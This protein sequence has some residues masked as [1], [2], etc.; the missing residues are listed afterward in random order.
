MTATAER[1]GL[2]TG[3]FDIIMSYMPEES[4]RQAINSVKSFEF[5]R[6]VFQSIVED[7]KK[8]NTKDL[9]ETVVS[10]LDQGKFSDG[11]VITSEFRNFK[12]MIPDYVIGK[13]GTWVTDNMLSRDDFNQERDNK[14]EV[15]FDFNKKRF[16]SMVD[17]NLVNAIKNY[18]LQNNPNILK[19]FADGLVRTSMPDQALDIYECLEDEQGIMNCLKKFEEIY[20]S[21][22]G[23]KEFTEYWLESRIRRQIEEKP[24]KDDNLMLEALQMYDP[25]YCQFMKPKAIA[26]I[27]KRNPSFFKDE[28]LRI[29]DYSILE[30]WK[31]GSH[32]QKLGIK[33][34]KAYMKIDREDA[35]SRLFDLVVEL[36]RRGQKSHLENLADKFS[37]I[38]TPERKQRVIEEA[39]NY[40]S[41]EA[42]KPLG[43]Y[44]RY[45]AD[46]AYLIAG[47]GK[48]E[49]RRRVERHLVIA[50]KEDVAISSHKYGFMNPDRWEKV[51]EIGLMASEEGLLDKAFKIFSDADLK[52]VNTNDNLFYNTIAKSILSGYMVNFSL[53]PDAVMNAINGEIKEGL[54]KKLEVSQD[55]SGLKID[56]EFDN[57]NVSYKQSVIEG[58]YRNKV[59]IFTQKGL[60]DKEVA[61]KFYTDKS[62][63]DAEAFWLKALEGK[64]SIEK[65]ISS[66]RFG[67][68]FINQIEKSSGQDVKNASFETLKDALNSGLRLYDTVSSIDAPEEQVT[69]D[70]ITERVSDFG[71]NALDIYSA[72]TKEGIGMIHFD[73]APRNLMVENSNVVIIDHECYKKGHPVMMAVSLL[74]NP[75]NQITDLQR[76][77]LIDNVREQYPCSDE[78]VSASKNLWLCRQARRC[79]VD[80]DEYKWYVGEMER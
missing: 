3:L 78:L 36:I 18:S 32:E 46:S 11:V 4:K 68:I 51:Y 34:Y 53:N 25:Q 16:S 26:K 63:S 64:V 70:Y 29:A 7:A 35:E 65:L 59:S 69:L 40:I 5:S 9:E 48:D 75:D 45:L 1:L 72:I 33:T 73:Y 17:F 67:R 62:H 27:L 44:G 52:D 13:L 41:R 74:Y 58:E 8:G 76:D 43:D 22:F 20:N 61:L 54:V 55:N 2:H 30:G 28:A 6:E 12:G 10:V 39:D 50:D 37:N 42:R 79:D 23:Q 24:F 57:T 66:E 15:S 49:S 19:A 21:D 47:I 38:F 71:I 14:T 77:E 60:G 56:I 80:S 31:E